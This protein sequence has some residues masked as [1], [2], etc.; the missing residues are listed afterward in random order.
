MAISGTALWLGILTSISPCPLATNLV[1]VSY[2]G[3]EAGSFHRT[4]LAGMVYAL[5]RC[6]SYIVVAFLVLKSLMEIPT[7]AIFLQ[8]SMNKILGPLFI[9]TGIFLLGI[10]RLPSFGGEWAN[11]M[12]GKVKNLGWLGAL[13][14]GAIFA[15]SFCPVSAA[16]YFGSLIP[17]ALENRSVLL[18]PSLYG[19]GTALPVVALSCALMG[20]VQAASHFYQRIANIERPAR[21]VTGLLFLV[22]G[23]YY[24]YLYLLTNI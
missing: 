22:A 15:L 9:L 20:G 17:L 2:I 3:K 23:C 21:I 19:L 10:I 24:V 4:F 6:L 18:L 5:G 7:V 11:R 14:M 8:N 16:L 1:A 12:G 13:L